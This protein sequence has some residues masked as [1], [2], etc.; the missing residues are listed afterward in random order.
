MTTTASRIAAELA[1]LIGGDVY[2]DIIHRVAFS[3][4]ASSYRLVPQCVVA[5]R[6]RD[7]VTAV[8]NYAAQHSLPIAPRGAGSGV[9]GE[10]LCRGIVLDMT[11]YLKCIRT[12]E[13]GGDLITCEPGVVLD[14]LNKQLA[15]L[16]RKIG[17]DPSSSNRA[18]VGGALANNATGAHSLLYGHLGRHV[19]SVEAVLADGRF[20]VLN[21]GSDIDQD[22]TGLARDLWSLL[23]TSAEVIRRATPAT[24]RNRCGYNIADLCHEGTLDLA[25]LMAG[26]EGTLAIFT[27]ITLATV[28]LPK[29]KGLLQ[30]EF[31]SLDEMA[32]AVPVIM[33]TR[34]AACELMDHVLIE[35]AVDQ[36]PQHRDILPATAA[37]VLLIE[38]NGDTA[39]IVRDK[40]DVTDKAVG[41]RAFARTIITRPA[42]QARIWKS[43]KDAAP[44][45]Y[46]KRRREHPVESIEDT[47]VDHTR[48]AEYVAGRLCDALKTPAGHSPTMVRVE[49]GEGDGCSAVC[50]L[51]CS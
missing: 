41:A 43:R 4:D 29:A 37:A 23:T 38:H 51:I 6:T 47:S 19:R 3:T 1:P 16:G 45:L 9:A 15:L 32:Q 30:L 24:A 21:N 18:T 46:R 50:E 48:L 2:S 26:S 12:A 17:P 11:R 28:P 35:M 40:I 13:Q 36:L 34:P 25:K 10:S 49:I 14:D 33:E 20:V 7:D 27:S 44:L 39:D 42:D 8:V 22:R 5:P 31:R